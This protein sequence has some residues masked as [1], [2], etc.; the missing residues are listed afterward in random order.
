M[1]QLIVLSLFFVIGCVPTEFTMRRVP[2]K[3]M[4][5]FLDFRPYVEKGF[6]F[7]TQTINQNYTPIGILNVVQLPDTIQSLAP[8]KSYF[9]NVGKEVIT[10]EGS[11]YYIW[12]SATISP[13][14]EQIL[15][16]SYQKA[17][18]MG[19]NGIIGFDHRVTPGGGS[20]V[21]GTVVKID[22]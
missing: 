5:Y 2:S 17:I 21:S 18:E 1:R 9:N 19:G 3:S 10:Y 4:T 15:E 14:I 7:S 12:K 13:D 16:I 22:L 11:E 20:E 6:I 8:Y